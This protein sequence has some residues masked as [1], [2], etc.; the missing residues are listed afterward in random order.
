MANRRLVDE[1]EERNIFGQHQAAFRCGR[2]TL[3]VL[4]SIENFGKV[5]VQ[6]KKHAELLFLDIAKAYDRTWRRLVLEALAHAGI[7]GRMAHF[8][9]R[10]LEERR[11]TDKYHRSETC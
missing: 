7:G 9:S 10:F 3:D 5:A 2:S 6:E 8:C 1:L 4:A 11:F